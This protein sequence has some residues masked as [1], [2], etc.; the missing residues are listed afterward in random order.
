MSGEQILVDSFTQRGL[1]H[2]LQYNSRSDWHSKAACWCSLFDLL[3]YASS[4][5]GAPHRLW[6]DVQAGR[7]GFQ[8]NHTVQPNSRPKKLDLILCEVGAEAIPAGRH[9]TQLAS[10]LGLEV[11]VP[12]DAKFLQLLASE[13]LFELSPRHI[14]N[15]RLAI[16]AKA[17]MDELQKAIPRLYSEIV[18]TGIIAR[19]AQIARGWPRTVVASLTLVNAAMRFRAS[20]T[21]K[22]KTNPVGRAGAVVTMLSNA[23]HHGIATT[24]FHSRSIFDAIGVTVVECENDPS[25]PVLVHSGASGHPNRTLVPG[26][27]T[28]AQ[29]IAD[30]CNKY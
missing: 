10:S 8:V 30:I 27:V 26:H 20:T 17:A 12:A 3:R 4:G 13:P 18:S 23:F 24:A 29:M 25:V 6:Q 1:T 7:L 16:E 22:A 28:Y 2:G 15:V 21:G 19:D 14:G 11:G 9:F 5:P